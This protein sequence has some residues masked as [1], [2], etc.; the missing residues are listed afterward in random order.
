MIWFTSDTH[1]GHENAIKFCD[2]PWPDA[3]AMERGLVASINACV[4]K[5][6][7]LYHLGDFSFKIGIDDQRRILKS[8]NCKN[9]HVIPGNHDKHLEEL[10][11]EGLI[12]LEPP[13]LEIKQDGR[14]IALSHYPIADWAGMRQGAIHVH[15]HIHSQGP[16]YNEACRSRGL[17]RYDA[18]VDANGYLPVSITQVLAFFNGVQ[19]SGRM[20]WK[21]WMGWE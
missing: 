6:D 3:A 1:F 19:P 14:R 8:L 10:A 18:G 12:F 5:G 17:L 11:A 2:R 20:L 7:T 15:G 13:I 21:Q 16:E 4:G 9:I